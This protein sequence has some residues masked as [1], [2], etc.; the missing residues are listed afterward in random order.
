ME[1]I[2]IFGNTGFVGSWVTEFF[3]NSKVKYKLYGYSLKPNTNPSIFKILQLSKRIH[4]QEYANILNKKKLNEFI[5]KIKPDKI[6]YLIS[7]PLVKES[8]IAPE[9]TFLTNNL[10]LINLLE[11]IR[12]N[13]LN[14]LKKLIIFTSDKVYKN[15]NLNVSLKENDSLGGEDPYSASKACQEIISYSY[16]NSYFKNKIEFITLRAGNIIGG[17]DWSKDRIVPDI[18][19]TIFNKKKLMIRNPFHVRPWQHVLDVCRGIN[20]IINKKFNNKKMYSYNLGIFNNKNYP[21]KDILNSFENYFGKINKTY[22]KKSF[23]EKN[24]LSINSKK[25]F[26]DLK[27]K[28]IINF[29]MSNKLTCEWYDSYFKKFDMNKITKNQ[30]K[31]Y[32]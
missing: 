26:F 29:K 30:I 32:K 15:D 8:L 3:L 22:L 17:G 23:L 19:R 18:I 13:K 9:K 24:Y 1:K 14:N 11:V 2:I 10:G 6:I 28:N 25:I 5:L 27:F 21:V 4:K 12:I 20:I 16:F 7:Q 31:K